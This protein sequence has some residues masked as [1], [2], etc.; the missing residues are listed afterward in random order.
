[1]ILETAISALIG[2]LGTSLTTYSNYKMAQLET[3]NKIRLL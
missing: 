1:M 3:D 2:L